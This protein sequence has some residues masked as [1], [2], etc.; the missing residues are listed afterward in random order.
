MLTQFCA[1]MASRGE[2]VKKVVQANGITIARLADR[3]GISRGQLYA[4]LSNPDMSFD[5][6]LAIGKVL[7][8]DFSQD[9]KDLPGTLVQ[10]VNGVAGQHPSQIQLQECQ[11]KLMSVQEQLI[12]ALNSLTRYKEKYGPEPA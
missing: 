5:R 11:S 3:I 10:L 7:H 2:I 1:T 9:F 8:Y 6:I 12:I 4:D